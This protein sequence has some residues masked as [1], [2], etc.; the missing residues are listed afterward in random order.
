MKKVLIVFLFLFG[1]LNASTSKNTQELLFNSL[2]TLENH[3]LKVLLSK[4]ISLEPIKGQSPLLY[5]KL[6]FNFLSKIKLLLEAG[7]DTSYINKDGESIIELFEEKYKRYDDLYMQIKRLSVDEI[8]KLE[9]PSYYKHK[10]L[11]P[12]GKKNIL[13]SIQKQKFFIQEAIKLI[14]KQKK[15]FI[16][17]TPRCELYFKGKNLSVFYMNESCN[18]KYPAVVLDNLK[19]FFQIDNKRDIDAQLSSKKPLEISYKGEK[20]HAFKLKRNK[21]NPFSTTPKYEIL[22]VKDKKYMYHSYIAS[23]NTKKYAIDTGY[24]LIVLEEFNVKKYKKRADLLCKI[25]LKIKIKNIFNPMTLRYMLVF[26]LSKDS[27]YYGVDDDFLHKFLYTKLSYQQVVEML[28]DKL[29]NEKAFYL[30]QRLF[31]SKKFIKSIPFDEK[32]KLLKVMK[33]S[34]LKAKYQIFSLYRV[35]E[36]G[37]TFS[38]IKK[39]AQLEIENINYFMKHYDNY[40]S[41]II[42]NEDELYHLQPDMYAQIMILEFKTQLKDKK[43]LKNHIDKMNSFEELFDKDVTNHSMQTLLSFLSD[44]RV[45]IVDKKLVKKL[46]A[47]YEQKVKENKLCKYSLYVNNYKIRI[48][49][50]ILVQIHA[51]DTKKIFNTLKQKEKFYEMNSDFSKSFSKNMTKDEIIQKV[52]KKYNLNMKDVKILKI[53]IQVKGVKK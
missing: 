47:E 48:Y 45:D 17:D 25:P 19:Y 6:D 22:F 9:I 28:I 1:I 7:V 38:D 16:V 24:D 37:Y 51:K 36:S 31:E 8:Q 50:D 20:L 27:S 12:K 53:D 49:I 23:Y 18:L 33:N 42:N 5:V 39:E 35:L 3:D 32:L 2:R 43:L 11:E 29:S 40:K 13:R 46:E 26:I 14:K 10:V 52:L 15:V 30:L 4:D 34:D 41:L 21:L 44:D